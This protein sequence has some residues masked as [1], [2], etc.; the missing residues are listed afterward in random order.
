M[1]AGSKNKDFYGRDEIMALI[2]DNL[3]PMDQ[4]GVPKKDL[5]TFGLC[6]PGGIGKT[7]VANAY[8]IAHMEM[9]EAIFW[10][11]AE[12]TTVLADEFS[13]I[14]EGLGL[15]LEGT[16]DARDQVV[17]R[18]LVKGWL[19]DPV[20]SYNKADNNADDGVAWLLIFDNVPNP[21]ILTD[22][23]PPSGSSGSILI[24]SRD[25]LAK[26][27]FYQIDN[28]ID[29]PPLSAKHSAELLLKLTW[30]ENIAEEE[31]LSLSVAEKLGGLPLAL[32]QMA[33][34]MIR[35]SLSYADFLRRYNEEETHGTLFS[36]SLEP[37]HKRT[38]Y[39]HTLASVWALEQLELSSGLLDVMS[40]LDPDNIP[41]KFLLETIGRSTLRDFPK[42][43]TEY[44]DARY[45]LL[46]SSLIMKDS[47]ASNL[48]IHRLIQDGARAK[49]KPERATNVF[50]AVVD[51]L[52]S[53]WP[54][55]EAGVRHH[56]GRWKDCQM[57]SPHILRLKEHFLR[58]GS[59]LMSTWKTN[60]S[61][62]T[63]LNELGWYVAVSVLIS[64]T[65]TNKL[66]QVFSGTW[67]YSRSNGLL[68]DCS[69][70]HSVHCQY[71]T[72]T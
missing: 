13:H 58:A 16:P 29:L 17:T 65:K 50:N 19:A 23:W 53:M 69:N 7:Q 3:A 21:D 55:A 68:P 37:R 8:A 41:E 31:A 61:F 44:Q 51:M 60:L 10:V 14:A 28:G 72:I 56:V 62:T 30:R 64:D 59:S 2:E 26:T 11:H 27:Q 22:F 32:T 42:T 25:T 71:Q 43:V 20:R 66:P 1:I 54:L 34:V 52:Y 18:E 45:E 67:L 9:F 40:L 57:L 4:S 5:K 39:G 36:L 33:G 46:K 70:E 15:V 48:T 49:M 35:Q 47:S 24:T 63:L 38:N 12:E 6:G